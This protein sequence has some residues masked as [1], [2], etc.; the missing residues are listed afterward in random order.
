MASIYQGLV[1]VLIFITYTMIVVLI[2]LL[3]Q[4]RFLRGPLEVI[5]EHILKPSDALQDQG[6]MEVFFSPKGGA[7]AAIISAISGARTSIFVAAYSFT[8][9]DIAKALLLA[10]QRDVAIKIILDKS[11]ISQ[12]YSSST[13]FINQGFDVKIDIKHAIYHHK[14]MVIDEKN[15][16]TGSFNFTKA[17][18]SKNAENLLIIKNNQ[19]LAK[20]YLDAWWFDWRRSLRK[21]EFL[22]KKRSSSNNAEGEDDI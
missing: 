1:R 9:A 17:A 21:D 8:S 18:E 3:F 19:S 4:E 20:E 11:Q 22:D 7:T 15:I 5:K 12:K 6:S 10:K 16:I 2:T 13:F 14:F